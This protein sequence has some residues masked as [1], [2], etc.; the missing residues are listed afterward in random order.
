[1][2][3]RGMFD[4]AKHPRGFHGHFGSAGAQRTPRLVGGSRVASR[5]AMAEAGIHHDYA[6]GRKLPRKYLSPKAVALHGPDARIPVQQ[7]I[8]EDLSIHRMNAGQQLANAAFRAKRERP[9]ARTFMKS[10]R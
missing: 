10:R 2:G 9:R 1:M 5:L 4:A 3:A 8:D 6:T 7:A